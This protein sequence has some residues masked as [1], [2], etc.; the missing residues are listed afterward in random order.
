MKRQWAELRKPF[1]W[2]L[3]VVFLAGVLLHYSQYL[4]SPVS[5]IDSFLGLER[6]SIERILFLVVIILGGALSGLTVG[7]V[8]LVLTAVAMIPILFLSPGSG[9]SDIFEVIL[10]ITAGLGFNMWFEE[11]RREKDRRER[12]L[13]KLE[14]V[15][16]EVQEHIKTVREN[17]KRIAVLHS[18][19]TAINQFSNLD[20]ILSTAV[21]KVM[22]AVDVDGVL[23]YLINDTTKELELKQYRGISEEFSHEVDHLKV[24]DGFNG[25][26]VLTGSSTK[27]ENSCNDLGL[28]NEASKNEVIVSQFIVPLKAQEK[29]VGTLC[30]LSHSVK[31]FTR[32]EE[33]LLVLI[34]A[35]L[36]LAVE[37]AAL[38]DEKERAGKRFKELFEKAHDAI[39]LQDLDGKILDAN[40]AMADFTGYRR[41]RLIGGDVINLSVP[42]LWSWRVKCAVNYWQVLM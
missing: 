38:N 20:S 5:G 34:G 40:Q 39:W 17:E 15:Q 32:D 10:V 35:E 11:R 6:Y 28:S 37:R 33:Q 2:F 18:V 31:D 22:E 27:V 30:A 3:L 23:I 12:A 25:R 14:A 16:R 21:D 1:F 9:A 4:P 36:G 41:E 29:V 19:T 24:E 7:L 8:Y 42:K 13:L 26:M